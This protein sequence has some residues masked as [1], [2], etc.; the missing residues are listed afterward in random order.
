MEGRPSESLKA[1]LGLGAVSTVRSVGGQN[2]IKVGQRVVGSMFTFVK[3]GDGFIGVL[4]C[5]NV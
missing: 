2:Q 4:F 1:P 5:L 3:S